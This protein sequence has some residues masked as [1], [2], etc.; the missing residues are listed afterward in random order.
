[1]KIILTESET[2]SECISLN[3]SI[4]AESENQ[5]LNVWSVF[6]RDIFSDINLNGSPMRAVGDNK[7]MF[8]HKSFMEYFCAQKIVSEIIQWSFEPEL[9][10]KMSKM[11]FE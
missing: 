6:F 8:I 4:N 5:S 11:D 3:D 10:Q 1:M 9:S 7:F 2:K